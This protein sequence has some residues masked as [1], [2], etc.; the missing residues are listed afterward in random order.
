AGIFSRHKR[1]QAI[2]IGFASRA[3]LGAHR[4]RLARNLRRQ[5]GYRAALADVFQVLDAEIGLDD[6][7]QLPSLAA[8]FRGLYHP[9][10]R[11]LKG[12]GDGLNVEILFASEV[13]IEPTVR[14][15]KVLHQASD[16]P[17]L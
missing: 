13:A 4:R 8:P 16:T 3:D 2:H 17:A 9:V 15:A 10:P 11:L 6:R 5:R 1:E 12:S 14:Q 7:A